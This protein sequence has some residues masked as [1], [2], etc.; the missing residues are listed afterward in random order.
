M[1]AV[2]WKEGLLK[3]VAVIATIAFC[4]AFSLTFGILSIFDNKYLS[5]FFAGLIMCVVAVSPILIDE[6]LFAKVIVSDS[7]LTLKL[8]KKQLMF[9]SWQDIADV[10]LVFFGKMDALAFSNLSDKLVV[11]V[12]WKFYC[13]MME[14]CSDVNIKYQIKNE[15]F[16]E[17]Y[18]RKYDKLNKTN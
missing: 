4:F 3:V 6:H 10:K 14:V 13:A 12:G 1:Q 5:L 17:Y 8:R 11:V 7:G 18:K 16:L 15:P 9:L 2:F